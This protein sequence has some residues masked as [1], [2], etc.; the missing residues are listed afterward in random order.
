MYTFPICICMPVCELIAICFGNKVSFKQFPITYEHLHL[1]ALLYPIMTTKIPLWWLNCP[2]SRTAHLEQGGGQEEGTNCA[3]EN[4][5][6]E[7]VFAP[8]KKVLNQ[9]SK[10]SSA[11]ENLRKKKKL[12]IWKVLDKTG[13]SGFPLNSQRGIKSLEWTTQNCTATVLHTTLFLIT[14]PE[15]RNMFLFLRNTKEVTKH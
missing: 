11:L 6:T 3:S 8:F 1:N 15:R 13:T 14:G 2:F 9:R 12:I 4:Y 5:E 10:T 7:K